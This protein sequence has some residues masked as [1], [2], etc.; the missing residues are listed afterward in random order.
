MRG[1]S[2][3]ANFDAGLSWPR[4]SSDSSWASSMFGGNGQVTPTA[5]AR[6]TYLPTAPLERPTTQ[7]IFSWLNPASCL[8]RRISI[9]FGIG[10]LLL[11]MVSPLAKKAGTYAKKVE[12][13]QRLPM[14]S[15]HRDRRFRDRDRRFRELTRNRSRSNGISG[16]HRPEWAVTIKRNEWSRSRGIRTDSVQPVASVP[17]ASDLRVLSDLKRVVY[18]HA[19]IAQR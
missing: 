3:W 5:L 14:D 15:G 19:K 12:K 8:R 13:F 16:H 7:P 1:K 10:I 6:L 9:T 17:G 2:G 4:N 18:L 11:G